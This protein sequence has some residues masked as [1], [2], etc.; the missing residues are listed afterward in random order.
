MIPWLTKDSINK[1]ILN[2][3]PGIIKVAW[4][5][6]KNDPVVSTLGAGGLKVKTLENIDDNCGARREINNS[7]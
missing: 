3:P 1:P 7:D 4:C 6:Q 2:T 5:S